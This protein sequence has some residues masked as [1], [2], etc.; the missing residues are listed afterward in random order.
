[1]MLPSQYKYIRIKTAD[2]L[3]RRFVFRIPRLHEGYILKRTQLSRKLRRL[4]DR[5][6]CLRGT[7]ASI[8]T[9]SFGHPYFGG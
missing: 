2:L 6:G 3:A 4:L 7:F 5:E 8:L 9:E 1:M